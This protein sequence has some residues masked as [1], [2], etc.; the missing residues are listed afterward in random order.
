MSDLTT[1]V[2]SSA[3]AESA[4]PT[5]DEALAQE[6]VEQHGRKAWSWSGPADCSRA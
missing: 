4:E 1:S 3:E 6:L 5:V 2:D